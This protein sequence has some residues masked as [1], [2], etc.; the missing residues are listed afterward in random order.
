MS[1][2]GGV[3][4]TQCAG[5]AGW[6]GSVEEYSRNPSWARNM[7]PSTQLAKGMRMGN[8]KTSRASNRTTSS[9]LA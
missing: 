1:S 5:R 6:S 8:Q 7:R 3:R 2:E 9:T 4:P